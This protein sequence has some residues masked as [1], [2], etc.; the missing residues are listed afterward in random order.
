MPKHVFEVVSKAIKVGAAIS[1][2]DRGASS[3]T[4]Q[5]FD[6]RGF[7]ELICMVQSGAVTGSPTAMGLSVT[8]EHSDSPSG[9][10]SSAFTSDVL[11]NAA[12]SSAFVGVDLS[13]LKRYCRFVLS[14]S[15][16]GGTSPSV[17]CSAVGVL[18][19]SDSVP[20]Q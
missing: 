12:N 4:S 3:V 10:F 15:F 11:V 6:R 8:V 16:T 13:G 1:P 2:A 5:A 17:L 18:A 9:S 14:V 20:A 19:G 7:T